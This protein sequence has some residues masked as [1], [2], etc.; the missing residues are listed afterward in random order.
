MMKLFRGEA[1]SYVFKQG[2]S[3]SAFFIIHE[4]TVEVS[5]GGVVKKTLSK[6]DYFGELALIYMAMRSATIRC[7]TPCFFWCITRRDFK[8]T[9][10]NTVRKNYSMARQNIANLPLFGFLTD[11][12]K[13]SIAYA[14]ISLKYENG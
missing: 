9:L 8:Q 3:A 5:I 12:Q 13:D 6:G 4:G 1:G 14:M 2:D 7:L 10:E 11:Q